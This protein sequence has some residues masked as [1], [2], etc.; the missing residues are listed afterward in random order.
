M[1]TRNLWQLILTRS[2]V[3]CCDYTDSPVYIND[4][5]CEPEVHCKSLSVYHEAMNAAGAPYTSWALQRQGEGR[6]AWGDGSPDWCASQWAQKT[7]VLS[8]SIH[9]CSSGMPLRVVRLSSLLSSHYSWAALRRMNELNSS[10]NSHCQQQAD[11]QVVWCSGGSSD[12]QAL[13]EICR[14]RAVCQGSAPEIVGQSHTS[15]AERGKA[16]AICSPDNGTHLGG[17]DSHWKWYQVPFLTAWVASLLM[18][19]ERDLTAWLSGGLN[20]IRQECKHVA[21]GFGLVL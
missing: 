9:L 12:G 1:A 6:C 21:R 10:Q 20:T 16:G 5:V 2:L 11:H 19:P 4:R 17:N 8:S 18:Q 13:W 7:G 14:L 3:C 15:W